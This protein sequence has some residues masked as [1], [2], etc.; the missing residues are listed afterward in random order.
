VVNA[1]V[2]GYSTVTAIAQ[3]TACTA[4]KTF[5]QYHV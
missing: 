1:D 2:E 4:L 3:C 5:R